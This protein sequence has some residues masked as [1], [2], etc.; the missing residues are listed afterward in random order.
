[1]AACISQ[2]SF[3]TDELFTE[4]TAD[5]QS[6]IEESVTAATEVLPSHDALVEHDEETVVAALDSIDETVDLDGAETAVADLKKAF[7]LGK[8]ADAFESA[9]ATETEATI[10]ELEELVGT[11]GSITSA[12]AEL[13]EA[14][15]RY[16]T[17]VESAPVT[18]FGGESSDE[19]TERTVD[20]ATSEEGDDEES[21]A[22]EAGEEA[23]ASATDEQLSAS[24]TSDDS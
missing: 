7:L 9:Y 12:S 2:A 5:V 24:D 15:A 13:R 23:S 22:E 16:S 18:D 19:P 21:S 10:S 6:E 20:D 17:D 1:M 8:R 11:L 4:A 3:D 14:L